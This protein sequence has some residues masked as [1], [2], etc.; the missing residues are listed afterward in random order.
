M[1]RLNKQQ[2]TLIAKYQEVVMEAI[3][4]GNTESAKRLGDVSKALSNGDYILALCFAEI[5]EFSAEAIE[6]LE[7]V[8]KIR[9]VS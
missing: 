7:R 1:A 3:S 5:Y 6:S 8:F 4:N 9:K 2:K